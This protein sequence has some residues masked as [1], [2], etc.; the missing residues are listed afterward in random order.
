MLAWPPMDGGVPGVGVLTS[1]FLL[2]ALTLA[3]LVA[4]GG[5][6]FAA[7]LRVGGVAVVLLAVFLVLFA[8][9][10][11]TL[12]SLGRSGRLLCGAAVLLVAWTG[13][14]VGWSI[15]PDRSWEVFNK[16]VVYAV[17]LGLGLL[18]AANAGRIAG[19]LGAS[20]L[21]ACIG[22]VLVW[23]LASKAIPAL[24]SSGD[25]VARLNV[26]VDYWNALALVADAGLALALW[27]GVFG[28]AWWRRIAGG[29][30]AYASALALLLSVSRAGLAAAVVVVAVWLLCSRARRLE[31]GL[32]LAATV[33]PA[34]VVAGWAFTRPALVETGA[35]H[36][37]RVS[38]GAGFGVLAL[39]GAAVAAGL[40]HFGSRRRLAN[41]DRR[42]L[43]RG[44]VAAL[45]A[46]LV[47]GAVA[48]VVAVGNPVTRAWHQVTAPCSEVL[49][50]SGRFAS[51][52][53]N[54]RLCWWTEAW[55]VF[56]RKVP[57][58]AGA[59]SFEVARK[60]FRKNA[61]TVTEPHS[62]PLQELS[63]GGIV[64]FVLFLGLAGSAGAACVCGVRRLE[65]PERHAAVAL[66]GL[67]VAYAVHALV[68][69]DWDFL[70]VTAPT[71]LALGVVAAAGRPLL[72]L[73]ARPLLAAA[74][75]LVA[76]SLVASFAFP[77]LAVRSNRAAIDAID[78]GALA[79]AKDDA[80]R[81]RFL[82]PLSVDSLYTLGGIAL[83]RGDA[84]E[85]LARYVQA[86]DLQPENPDTW[87]A[88]GSY[89]FFARNMCAAYRFLNN[90][91]TL[92]PA[93]SE[94]VEG[95]ILDRARAAVNRGACGK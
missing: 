72:E 5:S 60:R 2:G 8:L 81:A 15:V 74:S 20:L 84:R 23:A 27:L 46:A 57:L 71:M 10:L 80:D 13:A 19:Q 52:N 43:G 34:A 30:L 38:D 93:G 90:A 47:I 29:L 4:G 86:V 76:V 59:G 25:T 42:K 45:A 82:D 55:R 17:F 91:Y 92:D 16:T 51:L 40:V 26:P 94:W 67:P 50:T 79:K 31:G 24:D 3:A 58:G 48:L 69:Y 22:I 21:G 32:F 35:T 70:A 73:R 14:S 89:E 9:G 77:R 64:A 56:A 18:L 61:A 1:T 53:P 85:A 65:G 6:G 62:V 12:P 78:A 28:E 68:D 41:D 63:D 33:V 49:N 87:Y 95:G 54:G 66:L 39:V 36:A 7:L 44:L 75:A 83:R 11:A 37:D 88:L